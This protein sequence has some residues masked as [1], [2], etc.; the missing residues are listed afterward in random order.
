MKKIIVFGASG[1]T[2]IQVV[3]QALDLGYEVTAVVRNP[4]GFSYTHKKLLIVKGDVLQ[5]STFETSIAG[6]DAAITCLGARNLRPTTIYSKGV[7][8]VIKAM[9][10]AGVTRI[11]CLSASAIEIEPQVPFAVRLLIKYILQPLL[12]NSFADLRIMEENLKHCKDLNWTIVR[13]PSL[14]NKAVTGK[15]RI[16]INEFLPGQ[17]N[18]SRADVAHYMV[19]HIDDASSYQAIVRIGD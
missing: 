3:K 5:L 16:A 14:N 15:Y 17:M 12:K 13:P 4:D 8:N 2:G 7:T 18:I 6:K 11:I 19:N 9:Q 10:K 1:R